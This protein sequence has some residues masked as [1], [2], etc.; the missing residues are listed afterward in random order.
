MFETAVEPKQN[1]AWAL[2]SGAIAFATLVSSW[3][4]IVS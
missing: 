1:H 3:Y 2:F 4:W